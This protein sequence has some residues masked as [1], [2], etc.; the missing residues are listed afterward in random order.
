MSPMRLPGAT[1]TE[2]ATAA[3]WAMP[4]VARVPDGP[5]HTATGTGEVRTASISSATL[6][7]G[8]TVPLLLTW[9]TSHPMSASSA[10]ARLRS[11]KRA[12]TGSRSPLTVMTASRPPRSPAVAQESVCWAPAA[13]P[14]RP[15]SPATRSATRARAPM[16]EGPVD[17]LRTEMPPR[18]PTT[19][20]D[21]SG[22]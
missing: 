21:E 16:T 9:R 22:P 8:T 3:I 18:V 11:M 5:T 7:S 12:S 14:P 1:P 4:S 17:S 13:L 15:R 10:S 19:D 20:G 6:S 2:Q